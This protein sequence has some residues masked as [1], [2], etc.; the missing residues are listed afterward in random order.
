MRVP[1]AAAVSCFIGLLAFLTFRFRSAAFFWAA[2]LAAALSA[3]FLAIACLVSADKCS[4]AGIAVESRAMCPMRRSFSRG[5]DH[6]LMQLL[7]QPGGGEL[8]KGA[9]ELRFMRHGTQAGPATELA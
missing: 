4:R 7:G 2:F 1:L 6:R 8:G 3:F 9:G 5:G